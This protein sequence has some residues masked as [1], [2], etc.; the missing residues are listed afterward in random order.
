MKKGASSI[1]N[2]V[3]TPLEDRMQTLFESGLAMIIAIQNMG[4]WL[5]GPMKFFSYLGTEDF[6]FA[7]LPLI[8]W[9]INAS[10]GLRVGLILVTSDLLNYIA[11]LLLAGPRPYWVSSD[12]KGLWPE[13]GFGIPSGHAQTAMS[14][15]GIMAVTLKKPWVWVTTGLLIFFIGV[16]RVHLG[17]HFPHDVFAGWVMG[18]LLLFGFSRFWQPVVG[19]FTKKTMGQQV[20]YAF[21]VSV[22]FILAGLSAVVLRRD[23]QIPQ[24]WI[25]NALLTGTAPDPIDANG[26]FTT[27]GSLFGLAAGAAWIRQYGGYQASGPMWQRVVRYLIGLAGVL[28]LWMGL[29]AVFPRGD[30][31]LFYI[32][33]YFR[34]TLVALWVIAGAPWVFIRFNL[35]KQPQSSI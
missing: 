9:C 14:I 4:D 34:Y 7:V 10:L 16:S 24:Q 11:K 26:I 23:F 15:W 20:W 35:A 30:E 3:K 33:R 18:G 32:L 29:G 27:A 6:F 12:V 31:L 2:Q 21:L 17:A 28:V 22:V 8:Y 19:W 13:T 5:T 25:S 1:P